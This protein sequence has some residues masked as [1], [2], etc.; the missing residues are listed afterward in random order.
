M[1]HSFLKQARWTGLILLFISL[2]Y[3]IAKAAPTC[4]RQWAGWDSVPGGGTIDGGPS[5]ITYG[6]D[7]ELFGRSGSLLVT[8]SYHPNDNRWSGWQAAAPGLSITNTPSATRAD[9]LTYIFTKA[10]GDNLIHFSSRSFLEQKW[11]SWQVIPG[12]FETPSAVG[13]FGHGT[14]VYV[15]ARSATGAIFLNA[16][17]VNDHWLG[18]REIPGGWQTD[19]APAVAVAGANLYVFVKG[20]DGV[21]Y[22]NRLA[23]NTNT[24]S[25][26]RAVPGGGHTDLALSVAIDRTSL[27]LVG[28]GIGDR[29]Q[30]LN[31]MNLAD[32][33]WSGWSSVG[34]SGVTDEITAVASSDNTLGLVSRGIA[35]HQLYFNQLDTD[36]DCDGL[37]DHVERVLLDRFRPYYRFSIDGGPDKYHPTDALWFVKNS[38]L[39][40]AQDTGSLVILNFGQLTDNPEHLLDIYS[41]VWGWT[42]RTRGPAAI[43]QFQLLIAEDKK[44]GEPD[45]EKIKANATGLYGHVTSIN[46]PGMNKGYKIEYWQFYAFNDAPVE[47]Y[48]HQ[49]DWE[50]VQLVV[51]DDQQTIIQVIHEVHGKSIS[52]TLAKSTGKKQLADGGFEFKGPK[53]GTLFWGPSGISRAQNSVLRLYC[54]QGSCTHPEVYIEH[55]GHASWPVDYMGWV[56]ARKHN[57]LGESYLVAAP[58]NL[59]EVNAPDPSCLGSDIILHY[60]GHWG[61]LGDNPE[62]PTLKG[63]WG[64]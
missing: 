51:A 60:N 21:A 53:F 46:I 63:S 16:R 62:G 12:G 9:Q 11:S 30:Y 56:G 20:L 31:L 1:I 26:W 37:P 57:G 41:S 33:S 15:V 64:H 22:F 2:A 6:M 14:T 59:G 44:T 50:N 48:R 25:G 54:Y 49:G 23:L 28:H 58:C 42:D 7:F 43:T 45:F 13:I 4:S 34:G 8:N 40:D 38:A 27:A 36:T 32:E 5:V 52:F 24:W 61:A 35:V 39:L 55:S 19:A 29:H 18:W 10:S 17:Q 47:Q 3:G